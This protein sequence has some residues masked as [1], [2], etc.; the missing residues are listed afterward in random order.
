MGWK[1]L[2]N[3]I[4]CI[5]IYSRLFL[6]SSYTIDCLHIYRLKG[7]T[8]LCT[9]K[10]DWWNFILYFFFKVT[11]LPKGW[12]WNVTKAPL[13]VYPFADQEIVSHE[14]W[15]LDSYFFYKRRFLLPKR[16]IKFRPQ[17]RLSYYTLL[18]QI[19][20]SSNRIILA[21]LYWTVGVPDHPEWTLQFLQI[22]VRNTSSSSNVSLTQTSLIVFSILKILKMF[23]RI[24]ALEFSLND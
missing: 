16:K 20:L 3:K 7:L 22:A 10:L 24:N 21:Y 1:I 5:R 19:D 12:K 2:M 9:Y 14:P 4:N 15:Y 18:F 6:F 8:N 13:S 11:F 23:L 17:L